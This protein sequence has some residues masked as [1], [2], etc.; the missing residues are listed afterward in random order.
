MPKIHITKTAV[1]KLS[2]PPSGRVDYFDDTLKGFGVRVSAHSKTYFALRRVHGRLVRSKIDTTDKITTEKARKQAEGILADMGRGINPNEEKRQARQRATE[3]KYKGITLQAALDQYIQKGK[4]KPRTIRTYTDLFKLYLADWLNKPA[5]DITREMVRSRHQKIAEDKR[6]RKRLKKETDHDGSLIHRETGQ[7]REAAADNCMRTLRAVLNY[8]FEDDDGTPQFRNPVDILSSK[9]KKAWYKVPRRET[10]IKNSELP[11]WY[12]AV[13]IL[14]NPTMRD[15]LVLLLFTGLRRQEGARIK[16][17]HI[18]FQEQ[19]VTIPDTKNKKIHTLPLSNHLM[20]L[21]L[22]RKAQ[23]NI[24]VTE[25]EEALTQTGLNLKDRQILRNQVAKAKSRIDSE[26]VFPGDGKTGFITEP[27]RAIESI[28]EATGIVFTC[29]DLRRTFATIAE[30]L[31]VSIY[32]VKAL[33]NHKQQPSDVTGGYII[34]NTDRLREPMQKI[35][36]TILERVNKQHGKI[37]K[38]TDIKHQVPYT[39]N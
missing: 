14:E 24:E 36:D 34:L 38:L 12:K 19:C 39:G 33:L 1:Q 26:Y 31:D 10:L 13:M 11:A 8:A 22:E 9:K 28:T 5:S 21:L 20:A 15:Y 35:T 18:D 2:P 6:Q 29:H 3:E 27:K 30:S 32:T 17:K 25:T 23:L 16:W 4:L 37:I 7:P